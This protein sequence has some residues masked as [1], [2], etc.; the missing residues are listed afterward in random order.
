METTIIGIREKKYNFI[1]GLGCGTLRRWIFL[2]RAFAHVLSRSCA[3][4]AIICHMQA[5]LQEQPGSF[6]AFLRLPVGGLNPIQVFF[7]TLTPI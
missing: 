2:M 7:G 6:V 5:S 4:W 3:A 1:S